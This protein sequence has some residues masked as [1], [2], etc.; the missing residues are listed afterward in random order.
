MLTDAP[1][2]R[3]ATAVVQCHA[4]DICELTTAV[5]P[6]TSLCNLRSGPSSNQAEARF[7]ECVVR[8][9]L[10]YSDVRSQLPTAKITLGVKGSLRT[11]ALR[12]HNTVLAAFPNGC[13][14]VR[15]RRD[16]VTR[17]D[18]RQNTVATAA[19]TRTTTSATIDCASVTGLGAAS[20]IDL[21]VG[22]GQHVVGG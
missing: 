6:L 7:P 20:V 13:R 5:P 2:H 15:K 8:S 22:Y 12:R 4:C 19:I 10:K 14:V 3:T 21:A 1:T 9:P 18:R 17:Y 11:A 16:P